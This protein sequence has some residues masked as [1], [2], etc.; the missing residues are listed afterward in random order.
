MNVNI[1]YAD[2]DMITF[3][4]I[5]IIKIP[6]NECTCG[7]RM[8]YEVCNFTKENRYINTA[9]FTQDRFQEAIALYKEKV[10]LVEEKKQSE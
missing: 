7:Y 10:A 6:D 4:C 3:P 2:E 1:Y 9:I 8:Q 5:R